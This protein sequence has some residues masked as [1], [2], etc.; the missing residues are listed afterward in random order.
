MYRYCKR[1]RES[2]TFAVLQ[3]C[4]PVAPERNSIGCATI[5]LQTVAAL[6]VCWLGRLLRSPGR[7]VR[8][9]LPGVK[10]CNSN[11]TR[12]GAVQ[13][14]RQLCRMLPQTRKKR[15][16]LG[17]TLFD[18]TVSRSMLSVI[19]AVFYRCYSTIVS[20]EPTRAL[21]MTPPVALHAP[22]TQ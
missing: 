4:L 2:Y 13:S 20:N 17:S 16:P 9:F 7:L 10:L 22:L 21:P 5:A 8:F 6:F 18:G 11:T 19:D 15:H 12:S 1:S 3:R 14:P